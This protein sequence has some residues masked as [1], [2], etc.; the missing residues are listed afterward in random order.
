MQ[1]LALGCSILMFH[2]DVY[3]MATHTD[4]VLVSLEQKE[5]EILSADLV[6]WLVDKNTEKQHSEDLSANLP[7]LI[8]PFTDPKT[9]NAIA[10]GVPKKTREDTEY[11]VG[12]WKEWT[13]HRE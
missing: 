5:I 10:F 8:P 13:S 7:F 11:C 4:W 2:P 9:D 6:D 12:I 1:T 3:T